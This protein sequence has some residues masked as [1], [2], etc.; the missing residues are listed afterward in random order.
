MFEKTNHTMGN[1][2]LD[3]DLDEIPADDIELEED[4][5]GSET[6]PGT[7]TEKTIKVKYNGEE[8]ELDLNSNYDDIVAYI[9]KGMNYDH[10]VGERDS[11]KESE[12]MKLIRELA[13]EAGVKDTK[14]F[15]KKFKEDLTQ[16]KVNKRAEQLMSE[17]MSK[18]HALYTAKLEVEKAPLPPKGQEQQ[19][20]PI[21]EQAVGFKE[22][23]EEYP[24]LAKNKWEDFPEDF[25]RLVS[26]GKKPIV[27]WQKYLL[28]QSEKTQRDEKQK[29]G[30]KE[31]DLGSMRGKSD[32]KVDPFL[33]GFGD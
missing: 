13:E 24:D 12:E 31:R 16:T 11:L 21:E 15:V 30:T 17:G 10:V 28:N 32:E 5:E 26:E 18:E 19:P 27:A 2:E 9:Q 23:L 4:V 6:E 22:L 1:D 8:K 3:F 33:T 20:D 25:Q 29:A 7:K 14:E